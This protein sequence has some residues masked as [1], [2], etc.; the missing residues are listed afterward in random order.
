MMKSIHLI[1]DDVRSGVEVYVGVTNKLTS[2]C[3]FNVKRWNVTARVEYICSFENNGLPNN[4]R[5]ALLA[6]VDLD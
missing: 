3:M 6:I 5:K 2:Y 4:W 1:A